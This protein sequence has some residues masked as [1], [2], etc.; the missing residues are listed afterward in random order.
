MIQSIFET[1]DFL[2]ICLIFVALMRIRFLDM[3]LFWKL[4]F[5]WHYEIFDYCLYCIQTSLVY[6]Q[7]WLQIKNGLRY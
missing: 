6:K 2:K 3:T 5:N 4:D 1:Y 7:E